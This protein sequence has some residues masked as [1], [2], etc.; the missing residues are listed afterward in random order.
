[1]LIYTARTLIQRV[2]K[3]FYYNN[4]AFYSKQC[5]PG[6]PVSDSVLRSDLSSLIGV[7]LQ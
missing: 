1:M 6:L 5:P 2:C 7:V 3:T 4:L